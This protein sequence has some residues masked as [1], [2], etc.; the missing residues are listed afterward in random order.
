MKSLTL[1]RIETRTRCRAI[2]NATEALENILA[3][4]AIELEEL[5]KQCSHPAR[6]TY[7]EKGV[8]KYFCDD[9][10]LEWRERRR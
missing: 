1:E 5:Q 4:L 3:D 8:Q 6:V 7:V 9:C 10:G 2:Q